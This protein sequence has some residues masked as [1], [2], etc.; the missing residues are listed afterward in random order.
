MDAALRQAEVAKSLNEVPVGSVGV[1]G[2]EIVAEAHNLRN[3]TA[4]P[5]AHAELLVMRAVAERIAD[6]RLSDLTIVVTLEP[7]PMCAGAMWASRVGG[8]VFGAADL[9]AGA[10]GS[11]YNLGADPRLN[12]EFEVQGGVAET[13]CSAI[14]SDF[15]AGLR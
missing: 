5:T 11:L 7:C 9:D 13:A 4:D 12:H 15:F 3:T 2:G 1:I 10:T 8:V 14:L 6:W